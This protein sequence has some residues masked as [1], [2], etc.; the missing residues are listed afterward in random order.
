MSTLVQN[1][2]LKHAD[3]IRTMNRTQTNAV[4][5]LGINKTQVTELFGYHRLDLNYFNPIKTKLDN[6]Q[7]KIPL[8][9]RFALYV[10][11]LTKEKNLL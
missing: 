3:S 1:T 7:T 5:T 6:P 2:I 11:R 4:L 10:G 9:E 8:E